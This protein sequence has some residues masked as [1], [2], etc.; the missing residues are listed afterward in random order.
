V[1]NIKV[2]IAA[3][4]LGL[5]A[6]LA[7]GVFV[8]ARLSLV[9]VPVTNCVRKD[10]QKL[11]MGYSIVNSI[12]RWRHKVFVSL[13][14]ENSSLKL[15]VLE[16]NHRLEPF[17]RLDP[18]LIASHAYLDKEGRLFV[19]GKQNEK[20][21]VNIFSGDTK[22]VITAPLS[23]KSPIQSG[24]GV[25]NY[26]NSGAYII[27][28]AYTSKTRLYKL[29][30]FSGQLSRW[31]ISGEMT[32]PLP[33]VS[34]PKIAKLAV[35][36]GLDGNQSNFWRAQYCDDDHL[37]IFDNLGN[38]KKI[39]HITLDVSEVTTNVSARNSS[40]EYF[41]ASTFKDKLGREWEI[42]TYTRQANEINSEV[43]CLKDKKELFKS[44]VNGVRE[45]SSQSNA[46]FVE[47]VFGAFHF[48]IVKNSCNFKYPPTEFLDVLGDKS[49]NVYLRTMSEGFF[50]FVDGKW[51]RHSSPNEPRG[52]GP[53]LEEG[54]KIIMC[55]AAGAN[56]H[57]SLESG[58]MTNIITYDLPNNTYE[59]LELSFETNSHYPDYR[60][61]GGL[62]G[63]PIDP[64]YFRMESVR[65][66][67][68]QQVFPR[69]SN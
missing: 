64:R 19:V 14:P 45:G 27:D 20:W 28:Y 51:V 7:L 38:W 17:H 41:I 63:P 58:R 32:K 55:N 54:G 53:I 40:P 43:V 46:S 18:D 36:N 47:N 8:F 9:D 26:P 59:M 21:C 50:K 57:S 3:I 61:G 69:Y 33:A 23:K 12:F 60:Q 11:P 30:E 16:S 15:F 39:N 67:H 10:V 34:L 56:P 37:Y 31:D 44:S 29:D 13:I 24:P 4:G 35:P 66:D 65:R 52:Q 68:P 42:R 5:F 1:N 25:V 49:G 6:V 62:V 22:R 48:H 2:R